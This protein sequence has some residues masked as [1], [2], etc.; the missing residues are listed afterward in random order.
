MKKLFQRLFSSKTA[1]AAPPS[2][3]ASAKKPK[4]P[5]SIPALEKALLPLYR[6][7]LKDSLARGDLTTHAQTAEKLILLRH[8][9][10]HHA[11]LKFLRQRGETAARLFP[12][13]Q[14]AFALDQAGRS[15]LLLAHLHLDLEQ[16]DTATPL[17][18]LI[19]TSDLPDAPALALRHLR[20]TTDRDA[21]HR[22][23]LDQFRQTELPDEARARLYNQAA[24]ILSQEAG[25][26][27]SEWFSSSPSQSP[28]IWRELGAHLFTLRRFDD[29]EKAAAILETAS[30]LDALW[31]RC[32][33]QSHLNSSTPVWRPAL[34]RVRQAAAGDPPDTARRLLPYFWRQALAEAI[35]YEP[36]NARL[37][38]LT[39]DYFKAEPWTAGDLD[40]SIGI[41]RRLAQE[42]PPSGTAPENTRFLEFARTLK[43]RLWD[44]SF[45]TDWLGN[46]PLQT[47][48]LVDVL[49]ALRLLDFFLQDLPLDLPARQ[50]AWLTAYDLATPR[51][52]GA[53]NA[54]IIQ[55]HRDFQQ[56]LSRAATTRFDARVSPDDQAALMALFRD[57]LRDRRPF[58]AI[59]I[60][61]GE[62]YGFPRWPAIPPE[63]HE[64]D[65]RVRETHWW[66]RTI[67]DAT[68]RY[69]MDGFQEAV[70]TADLL[71]IPNAFRLVR[72][73]DPGGASLLSTR[74]A[75]SIVSVCRQLAAACE[76]DA[77]NP[78]GKVFTDE[79]FHQILFSRFENLRSLLDTAASVVIVSCYS[80]PFLTSRL[81]AASPFQCIQI[82]PHTMTAAY[83]DYPDP[84]VILPEVLPRLIEKLRSLTQPGTLV[85]VAAGFAGKLFLPAARQS[86][87]VAVDLA[88]GSCGCTDRGQEQAR[89]RWRLP[90]RDHRGGCR[91]DRRR[92]DRER[93]QFRQQLI[94]VARPDRGVATSVAAPLFV[95]GLEPPLRSDQA[96][97]TRLVS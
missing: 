39:H 49:A 65:L 19:E 57:A 10:G 75:R 77:L 69:L 61:D 24:K 12:L 53:L 2:G 13:A 27:A 3:P 44:P 18:P 55:D 25:E 26:V 91:G 20:D 71:G 23:F 76:N 5:P 54:A 33:N 72:D 8:P 94:G 85:L 46:A 93:Q 64:D 37:L 11:K 42:N 82:P 36:D 7:E 38:D 40:L 17:L 59:R 15:A 90:C 86:G 66:A 48:K 74:T 16:P 83:S 32:L 95:R 28:R 6:R 96:C 81:E 14:E 67:P 84:E 63:Q 62:S 30:P 97:S 56:H 52:C 89:R 70:R 31:L 47:A 88:V 21:A 60:C 1:R 41:L 4:D 68:R 58:S 45:P 34:D 43:N 50:Q 78:S 87:G 22:F 80:K 9:D 92:R 51:A 79:R 35:K 29:V 73:T